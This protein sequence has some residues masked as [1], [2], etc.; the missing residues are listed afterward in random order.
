VFT[1]RYELNICKR[2][3]TAS[4]QPHFSAVY[5]LV[6]MMPYN[7]ARLPAYQKNLL[8]PIPPY[9]TTTLHGV[10]YREILILAFTAV[11]TPNQAFPWH[12][13]GHN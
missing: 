1:A 2:G 8:L 11:K 6:E 4:L 13:T 10:K 12:F 7:L 5:D 3:Y 9:L